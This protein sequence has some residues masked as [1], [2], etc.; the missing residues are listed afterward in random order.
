MTERAG[1]PCGAEPP[2]PWMT[3]ADAARYAKTSVPTLSRAIRCGRLVAYR[4]AGGRAIRLHRDDIDSWLRSRAAME[5]HE[6]V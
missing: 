2:S 5:R 3:R 6:T 4:I 1:E